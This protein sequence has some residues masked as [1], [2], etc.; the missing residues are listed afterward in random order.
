MPCLLEVIGGPCAG[1]R[2]E[3]PVG[4]VVCLGRTAKADQAFPEDTFMSGRHC[5]VECRTDRCLV[6]DLGSSNGTW[7]NGIRVPQALLREGDRLGL[8]QTLFAV[9]FPAAATTAAGAGAAAAPGAAAAQEG[10]PEPRKRLIQFLSSQPEPLFAVLDAAQDPMVLAVVRAF[11]D[12]NKSL[13]EGKQAQELA[14]FAPYLVQAPPYSQFLEKVAE[15]WG[16][17]WGI[18]LTCRLSFDEVRA[19]L[20]QFL[21]VKTEDDKDLLFRFYDPRILRAFLPVCTPEEAATLFGPVSCFLVEAE[22][23]DCV[24]KLTRG[25]KGVVKEP[26]PMLPPKKV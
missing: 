9:S 25:V 10:L 18:F 8:G 19:H 24:L 23:P 5:E 4:A 26:V 12:L 14:D 3:V 2:I 13:Y 15:A 11:G 1:R 16:G 6:R 21:K 7:V 17:N 20:R 22:E